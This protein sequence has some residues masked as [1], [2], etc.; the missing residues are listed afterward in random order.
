MLLHQP[1]FG[2]AIPVVTSPNGKGVFPESHSLSLRDYGFGGGDWASA[3]IK[4]EGPVGGSELR[5]D[6]LVV[7]GSSLGQKTTNDWDSA[8]AR[9]F[10]PAPGL[11]S[12]VADFAYAACGPQIFILRVSGI[13]YRLSTKHTA[14]TA[15][16]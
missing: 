1:C 8:L 10:G 11:S 7:L 13:K 5:Y 4:A 12:Q 2:Q 6:A 3:Y 9:P 15:I 14:G 16:G